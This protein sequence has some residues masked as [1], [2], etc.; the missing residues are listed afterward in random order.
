[1]DY[2]LVSSPA[3]PICVGCPRRY[4][5]IPGGGRDQESILNRYPSQS[6]IPDFGHC[7]VRF[8]F[9]APVDGPALEPSR[10]EA[11][12]DGHLPYR[13]SPTRRAEMAS[14]VVPISSN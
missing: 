6:H 2:V 8:H 3:G 11:F 4:N 1:M 9:G 13:I 7:G 10:P 12:G 14:Q 5:K